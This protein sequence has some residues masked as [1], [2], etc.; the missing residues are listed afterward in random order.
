MFDGSRLCAA[1]ALLGLLAAG[2]ASQAMTKEWKDPTQHGS[3]DSVLVVAI[4]KQEIHRRQWEDAFVLEFRARGVVGVQSYQLFP[5]G[6][7]DTQQ[8]I[9]AVRENHYRAVLVSSRLPNT[10]LTGTVPG[11]TT[12][13]AVTTKATFSDSYST[14][15]ADV[16]VPAYVETTEVRHYETDVWKT[17][18]GAHMIWTGI[19]DSAESLDPNI[20]PATVSNTIVPQLERAGIV[21]SRR[22]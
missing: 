12:T 7:P 15:W 11:H 4:R 1:L 9:R 22:R 18:E 13:Q 2:C 14:H 10:T 8:V 5:D 17:G 16:Q 6:A 20:I 3:I 21:P 19:C